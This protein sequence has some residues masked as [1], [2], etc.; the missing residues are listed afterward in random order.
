[1]FPGK[2]SSAP[3][4][5]L[6]VGLLVLSFACAP[7]ASDRFVMVADVQQVM[8]RILEP[9]AE[10]YW[11]AV[12][13]I[14]DRDEGLTE[15]RPTTPEEWEAVVNAAYAVAETGNLLMMEERAVDQGSWIRMSEEM[16]EAAERA[17]EAAEAQNEQAV[18]DMGAELYY[19]CTN[20]HATYAVDLLRPNVR[21]EESSSETP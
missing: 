6:L 4:K 1:M 20:C 3:R 8:T 7:D 12:G 9:A 15:I 17:I 18:F 11:D 13:W 10:Q 5:I 14:D 21:L 16:I 2:Q 19:S